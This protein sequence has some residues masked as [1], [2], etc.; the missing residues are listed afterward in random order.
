MRALLE[1]FWPVVLFGI[2]VFAVA[3]GS[4]ALY[5]AFSVLRRLAP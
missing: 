5:V 2:P 3:A 1:R 4:L